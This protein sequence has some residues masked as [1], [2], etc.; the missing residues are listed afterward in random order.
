MA[1]Y[2]TNFHRADTGN[3]LHQGQDL[4]ISVF[5]IDKGKP[6]YAAGVLYNKQSDGSFR[7]IQF[8]QTGRKSNPS[9]TTLTFEMKNPD[10]TPM[11]TGD[12]KIEIRASFGA[13]ELGWSEVFQVV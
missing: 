6:I 9:L 8:E 7:V 10:N 11:P 3:A 4:T 1:I 12:Y 13:G 2:D 5:D